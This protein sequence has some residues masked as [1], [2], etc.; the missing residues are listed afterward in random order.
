MISPYPAG[1]GVDTVTRLI[2]NRLAPALNTTIPVENRPGAG[3][4]IGAAQLARSAP[5]GYTL[6]HV[7]G[8]TNFYRDG[9]DGV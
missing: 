9:L 4:T 1:G 2:A 8:Y 6:E 5:D 3:A 7:T